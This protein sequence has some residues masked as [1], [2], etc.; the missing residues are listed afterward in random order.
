MSTTFN[1]DG[2]VTRDEWHGWIATVDG[3]PTSPELHVDRL[4]DGE[5]ALLIVNGAEVSVCAKFTDG[6]Q[7]SRVMDL[8]DTLVK[9]T[10]AIGYMV[11]S[12]E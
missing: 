5:F 6:E 3:K 12:Q 2:T 11:Y 10:V 1:R 4:A 9:D 8:L 7:A